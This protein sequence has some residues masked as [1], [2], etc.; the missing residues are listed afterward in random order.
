MRALDERLLFQQSAFRRLTTAAQ[1]RPTARHWLETALLAAL[2]TLI[3]LPVATR[4]GLIAL[5]E[6]ELN[7]ALLLRVMV[8]PALLEELLFRVLPNPHPSEQ[9][10]AARC[11][12]LGLLSLGAYVLAHPLV[13]LVSGPAGAVFATPAFLLLTAL[14]GLACLLTYRRSGSLWP[15][16]A[17]HWLVVASWLSMGGRGVLP[18]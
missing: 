11:W 9:R 13:G 4:A 16:V 6:L 12:A 15:P 7:G 2:F 5:G 10:S 17:L 14:L 1:C 3:A 8:L 18:V